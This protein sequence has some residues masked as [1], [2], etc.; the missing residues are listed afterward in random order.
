L[1]VAGI[2][3]QGGAH[4]DGYVGMKDVEIAY[5]VD[6]EANQLLTRDYRKG[7]AVP[8]KT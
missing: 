7:F 5:L 1:A 2:H 6:R 8:E 3:G 4:M